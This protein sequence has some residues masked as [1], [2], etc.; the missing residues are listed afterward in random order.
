MQVRFPLTFGG[1][2]PE[3]A[4]EPSAL[5][6]PVSQ[7]HLADIPAG[8]CDLESVDEV[9]RIHMYT[10]SRVFK[11]F[12]Q[13]AETHN[14]SERPRL[15]PIRTIGDAKLLW[16]HLAI[17]LLVASYSELANVS[18]PK[19]ESTPKSSP[20]LMSR[21]AAKQPQAR[22]AETSAVWTLN[23]KRVRR[24]SPTT[25][26]LQTLP[27]PNSIMQFQHRRRKH[28]EKKQKHNIRGS[29]AREAH[30]LQHPWTRHFG[31]A[32]VVISTLNSPLALEVQ[33]HIGML[34]LKTQELTV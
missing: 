11:C 22:G 31:R 28:P 26:K 23:P 3:H 33:Q 17:G 27:E 25:P 10:L 13:G 5:L 18:Q 15:P 2:G 21:R 12:P 9:L 16:S 30:E 1:V 19:L 7:A 34:P 14:F 32:L 29:C 6:P 24:S 20:A 8:S 4:T